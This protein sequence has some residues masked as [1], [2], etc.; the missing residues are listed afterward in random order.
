MKH[1]KILQIVV[2]IIIICVMIVHCIINIYKMSS[3]PGNSAPA[4]TGAWVCL[5][6]ILILVIVN[7]FFVFK[8]LLLKK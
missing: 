6:Y 8:R 3:D 4:W 2:N 7:A 5:V 1:D